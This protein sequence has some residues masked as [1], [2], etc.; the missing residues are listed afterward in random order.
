M[1]Q[2]NLNTPVI[3]RNGFNKHSKIL[4]GKQQRI[5]M[6]EISPVLSIIATVKWVD[7]PI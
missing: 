1:K 2:R 7:T 3:Y 5:L 6:T 4:W